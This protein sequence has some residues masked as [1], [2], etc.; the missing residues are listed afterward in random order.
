MMRRSISDGA[1]PLVLSLL[2]TFAIACGSNPGVPPRQQKALDAA[3]RCAVDEYHGKG[4]HGSRLIMN[5]A[6]VEHSDDSGDVVHFPEEQPR[7]RPMGL[8]LHI[9]LETL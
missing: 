9:E 6:K 5:R 2:A 8:T 7:G 1:R 4:I 3:R